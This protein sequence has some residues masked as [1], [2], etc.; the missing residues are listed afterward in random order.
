MMTH[1]QKTRLGIFLALATVIFLVV[2]AFFLV[3]KL[4]DPGTS[5]V[6][7]FRDTSVNGLSVGG[8]V[9]YRGVLVGRVTAIG[10]SPTD[11]DCVHVTVKIRPGL[12]VKADMQ[13]QMVYVGI[14]GQKFIELSGGTAASPKVE[15]HGDI[16]MSRGLGEKADDIVNNLQTT[17]KRITEV[18]SPENVAK[19]SAFMDSA[20][21]SSAA[22]AG[23]IQ[24]RRT[25]LDHTLASVE[26]ATADMAAAMAAFKPL[27]EN[28]DR[29]TTTVETGSRQTLD[30]LSQRFSAEELGGAITELRS[31]LSTASVSL[32]K[33]ESVLLDQQSQLQ[34]TFGSLGEA[35]DNLARFSREI[36]EEPS[37]LVRT[38]KDKK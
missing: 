35:I 18:L 27:V 36:A 38:R 9:K 34:R 10:L 25:S 23:L 17:A 1:E 32:K 37:S 24:G 13:A 33:L 26:K 6:I 3:P 11:P 21:K 31:F 2:A 12:V 4:N 19:F 29:L 15:A 14:T 5:Y 30:N 20:E 8:D 16:P 7:K 28:L 22:V